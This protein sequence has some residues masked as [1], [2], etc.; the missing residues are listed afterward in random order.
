MCTRDELRLKNKRI[1]GSAAADRSLSDAWTRTRV[2]CSTCKQA[3]MLY[4]AL[5]PCEVR[6]VIG[7]IFKRLDSTFDSPVPIFFLAYSR[8]NRFQLSGKYTWSLHL[9]T[10]DVSRAFIITPD[11]LKVIISQ[12]RPLFGP[13]CILSLR[14][15]SAFNGQRWY[16]VNTMTL[17]SLSA[18]G[19][20]T[21][22][23]RLVRDH[24]TSTTVSLWICRNL[25]SF[26]V[27]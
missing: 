19:V 25:K 26:E 27:D 1:S 7:R 11:R 2:G 24:P 8:A 21:G 23:D 16:F 20:A 14:K 3:S 12:N 13:P 6:R 15:V 17:K 18:S 4:N 9:Q 5:T 10:F 22:D